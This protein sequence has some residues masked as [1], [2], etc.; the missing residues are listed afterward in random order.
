MEEPDVAHNKNTLTHYSQ[1][2]ISQ[3]LIYVSLLGCDLFYLRNYGNMG[4]GGVLFF[5]IDF[6]GFG[7]I[8]QIFSI[9]LLTFYV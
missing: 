8:N 6:W 7:N 2:I 1:Q 3:T 4:G 5:Y 9:A